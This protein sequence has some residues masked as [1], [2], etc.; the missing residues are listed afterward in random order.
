[1]TKAEVAKLIYV[2]KATYPSPFQKYTTQDL[3]NMISAWIMVM[4]DY[5]YEQAS[6]GLKV[7]LS[8]DT[9]GFPPSPGQIVDNILKIISPTIYELNGME[10]WSVVRKAMQNSAYNAEEEFDKLPKA[11]QRAIGSASNLREMGQ[12][13]VEVVETVEQSN[14]IKAYNTYKEREREDSK[15]PSE[16]KALIDKAISEKRAFETRHMCELEER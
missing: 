11:C 5:T 10:A 8:S 4:S 6:A 13:K 15:I 3:E 7:Y 2:V 12:L 16:I 1:M 9:K 14:F